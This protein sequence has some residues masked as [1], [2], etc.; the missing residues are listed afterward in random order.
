MA[1]GGGVG[2]GP[3]LRWNE[4][5]LCQISC[6]L[7]GFHCREIDRGLGGGYGNRG[8]TT[9]DC[10]R[11]KLA[12]IL[13]EGTTICGD[14]MCAAKLAE[15]DGSCDVKSIVVELCSYCM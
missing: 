8:C 2:G 4:F 9:R 5:H 11:N 1:W 7:R 10:R 14:R 12:R 13:L 15:T 6:V 3:L